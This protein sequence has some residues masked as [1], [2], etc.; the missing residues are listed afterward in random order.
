M[1]TFTYTHSRF[2][3]RYIVYLDSDG[4]FIGCERYGDGGGPAVHYVTLTEIPPVPRGCIEEEI[5]KRLL[6]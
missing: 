1:T 6:P 3:D 4:T 2:G 5:A